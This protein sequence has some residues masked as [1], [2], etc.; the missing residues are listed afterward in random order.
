MS[1]SG[2]SVIEKRAHNRNKIECLITS[3]WMNYASVI[4]DD[5]INSNTLNRNTGCWRAFVI[6]NVMFMPYSSK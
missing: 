2:S 1:N 5:A 6:G 4:S 3:S